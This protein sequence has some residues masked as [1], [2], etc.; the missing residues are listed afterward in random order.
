METSLSTKNSRFSNIF[1]WISTSPSAWVASASA[2]L[3]R[4]AGNAGH[5]PSSIFETASPSS[6][7]SRS[8]WSGGHDHVVAVEL[9]PA[10]QPLEAEARH[11]QVVGHHVLDA[12]LAAG[13]GGQRDEAADLD[14][15][16]ADR[17]VG[18]AELLLAVHDQH[19]GADALDA[20]A[21]LQQQARE[22]LH[23]RLGGRVV[24]HGG[25]RA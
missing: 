20:R 17:V 16:G 2:M 15:V 12:Q 25:A 10:A 5:G 23:V 14:V 21:H 13:A 4:S 18:A 3:V 1:S 24:D 11:A 8:F 6:S 19:V 22:V 7:R 9:D